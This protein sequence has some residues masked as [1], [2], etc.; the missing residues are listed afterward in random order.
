ML[1]NAS[2]EADEKVKAIRTRKDNEVSNIRI[3][4][5]NKILIIESEINEVL[6]TSKSIANDTVSQTESDI[7]SISFDIKQIKSKINDLEDSLSSLGSGIDQDRIESIYDRADQERAGLAELID[8]LK[9]EIKNGQDVA[10]GVNANKVKSIDEE[11][12]SIDDRL[13]QLQIRF[14]TNLDETKQNYANSIAADEQKIK[15]IKSDISDRRSRLPALLQQ[16]TDLEKEL[17]EARELKREKS[18]DN[19]IY[20]LAAWWYEVDDV[21]EVDR[22]QLSK[23]STVWFGSI[24]FTI[25]TTG[26]VLA[27]ISYILR[28]PQ[29]FVERK[30]FRLG[31]RIFRLSKLS[32]GYFNLLLRRFSGVL[33]AV[34]K[35]LLSVA[36]VFRGSIGMP[37]QRAIRLSL[38]AIRKKLNKPRLVT[39]IK[40]VE[41]EKIV[42]VEKE[43]IKEVEVEKVVEV[44]KEVI[45]EVEV[46]KEVIKEVPVEKVV[47]QEVPVEII[48]KEL[49][50]VPLYSVDAGVVEAIDTETNYSKEDLKSAKKPK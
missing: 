2:V 9:Q 12:Q 31:Q 47:I 16:V 42:E 3:A 27:L 8:N 34:A 4:S 13:E 38:I 45:K 7:A 19:Q 18:E 26:T 37:T 29:A 22:S 25:A 20:R 36:E 24:A 6:S 1:V 49:V 21:T 35:L 23:V 39:E 40:E 32:F 50:Y 43:V 11:I 33:L 15:Q 10:S 46:E 44:E 14:N 5:Q 48:R 30:S 17:D 28:D 41:V